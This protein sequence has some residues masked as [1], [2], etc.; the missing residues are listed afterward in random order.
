MADASDLY[1]VPLDEFIPERA[2][3]A[4]ALR[5]D[6]Q[7]EEAD[8][9]SKLRKPSVAAWAVN[10]L[11][12]TQKREVTALFKAGDALQKAQ[13]DLLEGRGDAAGLR[14]SVT[15][16]RDAVSEL[17]H[18]ARGLLSA[19]GQE[20]SGAT[21][22]RVSATLDAAAL[23]DEAR[24]Q[25]QPGCLERE[26]QHV[27]LGSLGGG[28]SAPAEP[29]GRSRPTERA[30]KRAS[31]DTRA[32]QQRQS[33]E[34]GESLKAARRTEASARRAAERAAREL[35]R[36]RARHDEAAQEL[37]DAEAALTAATKTAEQA[38]DE[39]RRAEEE[40]QKVV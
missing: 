32:A 29:R 36:A 13:A 21:L 18:K 20:L 17:V 25:V 28:L 8:R 16:Q 35:D 33:R 4:K 39:H 38:T 6:G 24:A 1:G 37:E 40:L 9:V 11:V 12:R 14:E 31:G 22:D 27:G 30:A 19:G 10:Q 15:R 34:H 2:A 7:R 5:A 26:L 23:D 3:L